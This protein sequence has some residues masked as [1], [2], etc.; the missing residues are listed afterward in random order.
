MKKIY[1]SPFNSWDERAE[2]III[3]ELEEGEH[4]NLEEQYE[5][6]TG[7]NYQGMLNDMGYYCDSDYSY[8]IA[9]GAL[10][11]NYYVERLTTHHLIISRWDAL[12]V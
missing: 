11:T 2:S 10:Y 1:E 9:P 12:N 7:F 8:A 4:E 6:E 5:D 3:Y